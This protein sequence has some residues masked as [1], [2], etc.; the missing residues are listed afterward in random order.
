MRHLFTFCFLTALF[1]GM[2][3]SIATA[4]E[5]L[6]PAGKSIPE[7]IDYYVEAKLQ[8]EGITPAAHATDPEL[9]RRTTLD[10]IGRIPAAVEVREYLNTTDPHKRLQLVD[11]LMQS[12]EF[13]EY[14]AVV[15]DTF[16]MQG[17]GSMRNYLREAFRE[18]RRWNQ[19]FRDVLLADG[20]DAKTKEAANFLLSRVKDIDR[21]TVDVS[22]IFFGVN[23]SCAKCHDHP[24][25][26]DWKQDHFYGMKSFFNRTF[27][28]GKYL[29][30]YEYGEVSYKTTKGESRNAK[31][32]FLTGTVL[33]EPKSKSLSA[34]ER[35][36][37]EQ[38]IKQLI[39]QKKRPPAPQ[40]SRRKQLV[41]IALKP[42]ENRFFARAIVNRLWHQYF[43]YGLVMPLDQMHSGN[44]PSHPELLDWL[45]RDFETHG[46]DL[47]R[48]IRGIVL[49]RTYARSSRW[50]GGERPARSLFAVAEIKPLTPY[51]L[52]RS[53]SLAT[54]D[55]Q[56]FSGGKLSAA[57]RRKRISQA[58][59]PRHASLFEQPRDDFEVSADEALFFSNSP[60]VQKSYLNGGL[61]RRLASEKDPQKIA[62]E[63]IWSVLS[64]PPRPGEVQLLADYLQ[65]RED[66]KQQAVQQVVWSLLTSSEF[67][68]NH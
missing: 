26:D 61:I 13:A 7:V 66:R 35:R 33:K 46:Y 16:L 32:M 40:H 15:F 6:L 4:A 18:N 47:Q 28:A 51:Q 25:V 42:G 44:P 20:S 68:F 2:Q 21:L 38:K 34:K 24:L 45:A 29:G 65:S 30:E 67:R 64:R 27:A 36:A 62:A 56:S 39:K 3:T 58:A 8:A 57:E 59:S 43:G 19:V 22:V 17:N 14:Q 55:P 54:A 23:V 63:A 11:R 9:L 50:S 49:S 52:A 60:E 10:L 1:V 48:L 41:E 31:L 5:S 37:L 12:P 53:L